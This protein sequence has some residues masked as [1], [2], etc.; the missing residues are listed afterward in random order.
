VTTT[1]PRCGYDLSAIPPMWMSQCPVQG[2][3][4][5]CGLEFAWGGL[6]DPAL[7]RDHRFFEHAQVRL[8]RAFWLTLSRLFRPRA[9]WSWCRLEAAFNRK[10]SFLF[11]LLGAGLLYTLAELLLA[12]VLIPITYVRYAPQTI[13]FADGWMHLTAAPLVEGLLPFCEVVHELRLTVLTQPVVEFCGLH[14][15]FERLPL[16]AVLISAMVPLAF[17]SLPHTLRRCRVRREHILRIWLYG[18]VLVPLLLQLPYMLP[19]IWGS[20][21]MGSVLSDAQQ[22]WVQVALL[23]LWQLVWWHAAARC[24]LRLPHAWGI[25]AAVT[26]VSTLTAVVVLLI[27]VGDWLLQDW[28]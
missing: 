5:E 19:V 1:C 21:G 20:L 22:D 28:V 2:T 3:C 26:L 27:T 8:A 10:R 24:Y 23:L 12:L 17:L 16:V 4:S 9:F 18:L 13:W 11:V 25:A 15:E 7:Y 14:V 6:L